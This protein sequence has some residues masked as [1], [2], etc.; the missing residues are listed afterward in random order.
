MIMSVHS[1]IAK[2]QKEAISMKRYI[3][4]FI[5]TIVALTAGYFTLSHYRTTKEFTVNYENIT[6]ATLYERSV[7]G[8]DVVKESVASGETIR[9]DQVSEDYFVEYRA[10][11]EFADGEADIDPYTDS[12]T[13][14]PGFSAEKLSSLYTVEKTA[15][16]AS[17]KSKYKDINEL[18]EIKNDQLYQYGEWFGATLQYKGDS[19]FNKDNVGLVMQKKGNSWIVVTDPPLPL[20]N[21]YKYD[22][23]PQAV[24]ESINKQLHP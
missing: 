11:N 24:A 10:D 21:S 6:S 22:D 23:M 16:M 7:E 13:I 8:A 1:R 15:I 19:F 20:I 9:I 2:L 12:I 14:E 3:A 4:L 18:Y 17:M 5:V